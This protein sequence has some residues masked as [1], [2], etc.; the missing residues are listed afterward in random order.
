MRRMPVSIRVH[1]PKLDGVRGVAVLLVLIGHFLVPGFDLGGLGVGIF[2]VLSG[3]LITGILLDYRDVMTF[4]DTAR[5][6]YWRRFLRLSPPLVAALS[7]AAILGLGGSRFTLL[8]DATYLTNFHVFAIGHFTNSSHFW[9]LAVEEQFYIAVF[10]LIVL[11]RRRLA[12]T[13]LA[14]F[15]F[16]VAFDFIM[17]AAGFS[18]FQLLL[19]G[20][21]HGLIAGAILALGLRSSSDH[22]KSA[23]RIFGDSRMLAVALSVVLFDLAVPTWHGPLKVT[24]FPVA[25]DILALCAIKRSLRAGPDRLWDWLDWAPLRH[26]GTISYGLYVYHYFVPEGLTKYA[27]IVMSLPYELRGSVAVAI[28]FVLAEASWLYMEKPVLRLKDAVGMT[29]PAATE[30]I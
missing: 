1:I 16:S 20:S 6:F 3:F 17:S 4:A 27:P 28:S 15:A 14:I 25:T 5:T 26:I 11:V 22:F 10:P 18:Y 30:A 21:A 19:P 2:F 13:L 9:S 24:L 23:I 7:V 12:P 29:R 8:M